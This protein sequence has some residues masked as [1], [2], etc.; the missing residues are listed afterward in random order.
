MRL[1]KID[2]PGTLCCYESLREVLKKTKPRSFVDIGCGGGD[3][4]KLLCSLGMTGIGIDFSRPAIERSRATLRAEIQAGTYRLIEG[5]ATALDCEVP[6]CDMGVSF[7]VMEH[8][9]DDVSFVRAASGFVR[10][11]GHLAIWVQGRR[12]LWSFEDETAGHLRRYDRED[13]RRVLEAG[14]LQDVEIRSVSVPIGNILHHI[15]AW[16]VRHSD[17]AKKL[18]LSKRA[19]TETSGLREIPWKTAFP[20]WAKIVLNRHALYPL[21]VLQ[22]LFYRTGLGVTMLGLGRVPR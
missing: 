14:G 6:P 10:P 13:L 2:P 1:I 20:P 11:G 16:L 22:R 12:D 4:S 21:F 18:A 17:E 8:I 3:V 15:G 5:D 9:E 7:M 19:Q